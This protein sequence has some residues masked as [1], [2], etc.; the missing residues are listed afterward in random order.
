MNAFCYSVPAW[1]Q[2]P[3]PKGP[4]AVRTASMRRGQ[5]KQRRAGVRAADST[6]LTLLNPYLTGLH[7]RGQQQTGRIPP[8]CQE[9]AAMRVDGPLHWGVRGR[10]HG[11]RGRYCRPCLY[12]RS[13]VVQ[14]RRTGH[15]TANKDCLSI[16]FRRDHAQQRR[17]AQANARD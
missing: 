2:G 5:F 1:I 12:L 17:E 6:R 3:R 16:Q 10:H 4:S 7:D 13:H 8:R 11:H 14:K 9:K 15:W